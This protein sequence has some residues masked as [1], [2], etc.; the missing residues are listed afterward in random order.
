MWL[1]RLAQATHDRVGSGFYDQRP[2]RRVRPEAGQ[3]PALRAAVERAYPAL[4]AEIKPGRPDQEPRRVDVAARAQAYARGGACGISVLTDPDHFG[5]RLENLRL[6]ARTQ[7]P[8]LMKDFLVDQAQVDAAAAWGASAVL[9]I[10]RLHTED[11]TDARL[12]AL[13]ARAHDHGLEVLAEAVTEEE[14]ELSLAAGADLIGIN[15]RDLD[16]L[17]LDPDRPAK[18]LAGRPLDIPALHLSGIRSAADVRAALKV[19]AQGVLV[20][21]HLMASPDPEAAVRALLEVPA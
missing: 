15:V 20:G 18:L 2:D 14:L 16:T 9:A 1:N 10:A 13:V 19:G 8:I 3:R 21:S 6:A 12:N 5:G 7:L 17:E 4:I 11:H